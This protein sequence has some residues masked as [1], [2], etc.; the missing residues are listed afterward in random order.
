MFFVVII[1]SRVSIKSPYTF[2]SDNL[3]MVDFYAV[4]D[5]IFSVH[6]HKSSPS[7][8][9]SFLHMKTRSLRQCNS[10]F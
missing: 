5:H 2:D 1:L 8:L 9:F 4:Y 10:F 7:N 3:T 6:A